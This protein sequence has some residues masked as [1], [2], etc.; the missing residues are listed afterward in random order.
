[1]TIKKADAEALIT[2]FAPPRKR[3]H[4]DRG[5]KPMS[6]LIVTLLLVVMVATSFLSGIFGM[7]GGMILIGVLLALLPLPTAMVLH[8]VTQM[9]SN[10]WRA[11]LWWRYIRWR[12]AVAYV[13]GCVV[14]LFLWS[15]AQIVPEKPV[16]LLL[17]GVTP[18]LARMTPASFQ[19]NPQS[20]LQCAAYGVICQT[21]L[22]MTG[23]SGPLLDTFFLGGGKMD[24]REI[25]ATKALCQVFGHAAKLLYFGGLIEQAGTLD[26]VVAGLAILASAL[27]TTLSTR[28]LHAM[29]DVQYR[30]WANRIVTTI[31]LYYVGYG[32]YLFIAPKFIA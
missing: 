12:P 10:G 29:S 6:P 24:R 17:L 5:A 16:A 13:G 14:V 20:K 27:G 8:A 18:F 1:M 31:A 30:L 7:A 2:Q 22:L 26:P 19:P 11:A 3:A 4:Q 32:S 25:V 9:A 21:L 28:V 23:V 15:F